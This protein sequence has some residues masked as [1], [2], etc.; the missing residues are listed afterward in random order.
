[1]CIVTIDAY[2][3]R[4]GL[5][6]VL[7]CEKRKGSIAKITQWEEIC[8]LFRSL[9]TEELHDLTLK[10]L[11]PGRQIKVVPMKD[12]HRSG[13]CK[14]RGPCN[15]HLD[16]IGVHLWGHDGKEVYPMTEDEIIVTVD[17]EE[18]PQQRRRRH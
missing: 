16:D 7:Y 5:L 2:A 10:C 13:D 12:H 15:K 18:E 6:R 11:D 3:C 1:M 14:A 8:Y 17:L 9:L 4:H